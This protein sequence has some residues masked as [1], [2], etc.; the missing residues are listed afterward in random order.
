MRDASP[1]NDMASY[2]A[3]EGMSTYVAPCEM[4]YIDEAIACIQQ[5]QT[6]CQENGIS[7]TMVGVPISQAELTAYSQEDVT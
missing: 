5:I 2:L 4:N 3:Y 6:M 1:I 7:F